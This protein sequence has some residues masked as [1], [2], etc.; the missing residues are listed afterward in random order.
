MIT[1]A[2]FSMPAAAVG[3]NV[4]TSYSYSASSAIPAGSIVSLLPGKNGA[5]EPANTANTDRMLGVAVKANDSLLAVNPSPNKVQI[6]VTGTVATLVSSV[7]GTIAVG[8]NVTASPFDGIGMKAQQSSHV[9]GIAQTSL[10]SSTAGVQTEVVKDLKGREHRIQVGYVRIS[11]AVG[12]NSSGG[13][14]QANSLQKD[15]SQ[16]TGHIVP[17]PRIIIS[18]GIIVVALTSLITLVYSAIYSSIIAVGRNP[19]A[20]NSIFRGFAG[21]ILMAVLIAAMSS[22]AVY[23]LLR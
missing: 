6:A 16:L 22:G 20:K 19:L 17:L 1:T 5:V 15:V 4:S 2:I 7:N 13:Q 14:V 23:Y 18:L 12:N 21:I 3:A 11:I 9:I 10:N 8:D